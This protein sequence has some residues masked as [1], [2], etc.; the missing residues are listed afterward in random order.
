MAS[1]GKYI[2]KIDSN[3]TST[4]FTN[5]YTLGRQKN[6]VVPSEP[7][8]DGIT[9]RVSVIRLDGTVKDPAAKTVFVTVTYD[10]AGTHVWLEEQSVNITAAP[11]GT[12]WGAVIKYESLAR[13]LPSE[14][15]EGT[16]SI[17]VKTDNATATCSEARFLWEE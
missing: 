4:V 3:A 16:I 17:F 11:F 9:G 10:Q 13:V 6:L 2:H 12:G 8:L 15:P 7:G 14:C 5:A 1:A